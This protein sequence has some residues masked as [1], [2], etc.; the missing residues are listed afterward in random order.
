MALV[1]EYGELTVTKTHPE[2]VTVS[3][4]VQVK[5]DKDGSPVGASEDVSFVIN[6]GN[7]DAVQRV[8]DALDEKAKEVLAKAEKQAEYDAQFAG[9][10][11]ALINKLPAV[12]EP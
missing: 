3:V 9:V 10:R 6:P 4:P 8:T 11:T 1:I 5:N 2:R 12:V 7:A